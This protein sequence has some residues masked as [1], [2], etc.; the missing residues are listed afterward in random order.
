MLTSF[1]VIVRLFS[2]SSYCVLEPFKRPF[3]ESLD[4][5]AKLHLAGHLEDLRALLA[6]LLSIITKIFKDYNF[7]FSS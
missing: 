6:N 5:L 2:Q 3:N 1:D 4:A 7:R